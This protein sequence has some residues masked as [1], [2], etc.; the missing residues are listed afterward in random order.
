M[1]KTIV[2]T[3]LLFLALAA[4]LIGSLSWAQPPDA[5]NAQVI[6]RLVGVISDPQANREQR[7]NAAVAVSKEEFR[8]DAGRAVGPMIALLDELLQDQPPSPYPFASAINGV[9]KVALALGDMGPQAWP[10]VPSLTFML[11]CRS[12]ESYKRKAAA[13]ALGKI[14]TPAAIAALIKAAH[15]DKY[16]PVRAVIVAALNQL[17]P[18][19]SAAAL[20][21]KVIAQIDPDQSVRELA[22]APKVEKKE[23]EKAPEKILPPAPKDEKPAEKPAAKD[24]KLPDK[25]GDKLPE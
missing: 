5:D 23:P 9:D 4:S 13:E 12:L 24:E 18:N 10:A 8:K 2:P 22:G 6:N 1:S 7:I 15:E 11:Q 14:G 16:A 20:E 3:F 19:N 25:K 21:L 17:A